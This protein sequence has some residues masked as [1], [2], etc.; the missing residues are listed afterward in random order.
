MLTKLMPNKITLLTGNGCV[1]CVNRVSSEG[2]SRSITIAPPLYC[3]LTCERAVYYMQN[4]IVQTQYA[5]ELHERVRREFPEVSNI[6]TSWT[7][8]LMIDCT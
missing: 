4:S 5:T 7:H 3:A 8:A 1:D 2:H 6:R